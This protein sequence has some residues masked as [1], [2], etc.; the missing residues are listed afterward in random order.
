MLN[1]EV[2]KK[3]D[4]SPMQK[5]KGNI[6]VSFYNQDLNTAMLKFQ[7]TKD[8]KPVSFSNNTSQT[9]IAIKTGDG[10]FFV[11]EME[12]LDALNGVIAFTLNDDM[13]ARTGEATGQIYI[14][15]NGEKTT[16]TTVTFNFNINAALIN[17]IDGELKIVYIRTIEDLKEQVRNSLEPLEQQIEQVSN[18]LNNGDYA[19]VTDMQSGDQAVTTALNTHKD[20]K[21][22]PHNVTKSQV[23]LSNVDNTADVDKPVSN[24]QKSYIDNKV[25]TLTTT[26]SNDL[27]AMEQQIATDVEENIN[28]NLAATVQQL[29]NN[30]IATFRQDILD[31]VEISL[32]TTEEEFYNAVEDLK[33]VLL[34]EGAASL[35][36]APAGTLYNLADNVRNYKYYRIM[37]GFAGGNYRVQEWDSVQTIPTIMEFNLQDADATQPRMYEAMLDFSQGNKFSITFDHVYNVTSGNASLNGNTVTIRR[38]EG[39]RY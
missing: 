39:L 19:L 36:S 27:A 17:E 6:G 23:G 15:A 38:I 4:I 35:A 11:D 2:L 25:Q 21:S 33:P 3:I 20:D 10:S 29:V 16:V 31:E 8:G 32:R 37:Y 12:V 30:N 22:N 1:K 24:P 14:N 13:L 18:M 34:W 9:L 7:V 26:I 28:G 5:P